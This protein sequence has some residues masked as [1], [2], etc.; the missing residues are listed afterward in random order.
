MSGDIVIE[1]RNL[2]KKFRIGTTERRTLFSAIRRTLSG[3]NPTRD[4]WALKDVSFSVSKGEM[5]AVIGP[6]GAGKTTLL[7]I[8]AGI[9]TPT[10]GSFSVAGDVSCIFE[11]G[12][13]FNPHFTGL[14]NVYQYA[15]LHGISRREI[16]KKLPEIIE[17]AEL[18]GFMGAKLG[19]YSSGMRA[20]LAFATVMQMLRGIV[21]VDEVL[22][23]GD[24]RFQAKCAERIREIRAGGTTLFYVS[25]QMDQVAATCDRVLL[26][27]HGR[28]CHDGPPA[29]SIRRY[30]ELCGTAP[31]GVARAG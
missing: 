22:A 27:H 14:E 5:V 7:R 26:L 25:H 17:F 31:P 12:L 3:D 10:S 11:L 16:E 29:E 30:R 18:E 21:M 9:M 19:E 6:N 1:T 13:G 20:R 4:I 15:S 28:L 2:Y 8:L 23:V 24:E